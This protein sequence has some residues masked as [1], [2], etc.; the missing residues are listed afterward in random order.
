MHLDAVQQMRRAAQAEFSDLPRMLSHGHTLSPYLV[1][2]VNR[3]NVVHDT[4]EQVEGRHRGW[5]EGLEVSGEVCVCQK[6]WDG[7]CC[8]GQG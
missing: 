5:G 1:L 7:S 3:S 2:N 8:D 6:Y 4:L